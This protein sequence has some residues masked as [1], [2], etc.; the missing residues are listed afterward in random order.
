M[1]ADMASRDQFAGALDSIPAE[2][3]YGLVTDFS[4]LPEDYR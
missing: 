1:T 2:E 4:L 3:A